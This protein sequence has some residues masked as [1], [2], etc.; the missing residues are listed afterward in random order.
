MSGRRWLFPPHRR[1]RGTASQLSAV[2]ERQPLPRRLQRRQRLRGRRS[3]LRLSSGL[4]STSS[5]PGCCPLV[6]GGFQGPGR[7]QGPE[8]L[9]VGTDAPFRPEESGRSRECS[10][11]GHWSSDVRRGRCQSVVGAGAARLHRRVRLVCKPESSKVIG[12]VM[13][14]PGAL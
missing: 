14:E 4:A 10:S 1:R 11:A 7:L 5:V 3:G 12:V 9:L 8:S 2:P 13:A 6:D